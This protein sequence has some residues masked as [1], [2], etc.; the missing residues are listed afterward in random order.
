MQNDNLYHGIYAGLVVEPSD[1]DTLGRVKVYVPGI[2]GPLFNEWNA[3]E[4]DISFSSATS[5]PFSD[6]I[7]KRLQTTLPWARPSSMI[8]GG[9]T[10]APVSSSSGESVVNGFANGTEPAPTDVSPDNRT[11]YDN[12]INNKSA[13][14]SPPRSLS[15]LI[16]DNCNPDKLPKLQTK[17]DALNYM[18]NQ[19]LQN[20]DQFQVDA[21]TSQAYG[22]RTDTP[23][24]KA[25]D[26]T[27][28]MS[29]VI[30]YES[31]WNN[32]AMSKEGGLQGQFSTG[33]FQLSPGQQAVGKFGGRVNCTSAAQQSDLN[34]DNALLRQNAALNINSGLAILAAHTQNH[35]G[36]WN[37]I[38]GFSRNLNPTYANQNLTGDQGQS[39]YRPKNVDI[40]YAGGGGGLLPYHVDQNG[41]AQAGNIGRGQLPNGS[42]GG[43]GSSQIMI[44]DSPN[45]DR[46]LVQKTTNMG[47][48]TYASLNAG[49]Y[50]APV[51]QFSLPAKGAK[52][53]VMFEGGS[54]Q[55]PVYIGQIYEPSN[56][57]AFS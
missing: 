26:I 31:G 17:G 33:L 32:F 51:G 3:K 28:A 24:N 8:F 22:I 25:N 55:R 7:L 34:G 9:G 53:W 23:E 49:R 12:R 37:S 27:R 47:Q 20:I 56:V 16:S 50:G 36:N 1:P 45:G 46:N 54:P 40:N 39:L 57:Q 44:A 15:G 2:L 43:N 10:G 4:Q 35:N 48:N 14:I 52:V 29:S 21:A 19:V 41:I 42:G 18:Y 13:A 6:D 38:R 5:T 30:A 11:Y